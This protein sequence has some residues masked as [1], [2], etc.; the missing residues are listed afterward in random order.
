MP[1]EVLNLHSVFTD[2]IKIIRYFHRKIKSSKDMSSRTYQVGNR[3]AHKKLSYK[4]ATLA[5]LVERSIRN[6]KV[7]SSTLIGGSIIFNT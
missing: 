7:V 1:V 3:A 2:V 6:R 4:Q 5:Q